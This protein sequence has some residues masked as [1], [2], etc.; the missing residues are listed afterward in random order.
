MRT[1]AEAHDILWTLWDWKTGFAYWDKK[2][3]APLL[4]EPIFEE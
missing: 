2:A 4:R 3:Q 1:L